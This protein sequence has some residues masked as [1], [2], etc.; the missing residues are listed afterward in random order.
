MRNYHKLLELKNNKVSVTIMTQYYGEGWAISATKNAD[1]VKLAIEQ[2]SDNL[3][4]GL[5]VVHMKWLAATGNMPEHRLNQIEHKKYEVEREELR[6]Y[7]TGEVLT[8]RVE[9]EREYIPEVEAPLP[10][11]WSV[12]DN[13]IDTFDEIDNKAP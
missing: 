11:G 3:E 9:E 4:D 7:A 10:M 6:D 12:T 2:E 13:D 1:G 8:G 5:D